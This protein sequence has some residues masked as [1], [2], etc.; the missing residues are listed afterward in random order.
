[1]RALGHRM[2]GRF[3]KHKYAKLFD[4]GL[5]QALIRWGMAIQSSTPKGSISK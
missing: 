2:T 3:Q 5:A 1:M 4:I